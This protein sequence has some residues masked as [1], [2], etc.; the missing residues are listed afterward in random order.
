M[1]SR[2]SHPSS[3]LYLLYRVCMSIVSLIDILWL[4]KTTLSF[5]V[6]RSIGFCILTLILNFMISCNSPMLMSSLTWN[7]KKNLPTFRYVS[8]TWVLIDSIT[9]ASMDGCLK[10]K[11]SNSTLRWAVKEKELNIIAMLLTE[12]KQ[13]FV[14]VNTFTWFISLV[15]LRTNNVLLS[16]IWIWICR[17]RIEME[18]LLRLQFRLYLLGGSVPITVRSIILLV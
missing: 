5:A 15:D 9:T 7:L 11:F 12:R 6:S 1:K 18:N 16:V 4:K 17:P 8:I 2:Y 13:L 14:V 3:S 10:R